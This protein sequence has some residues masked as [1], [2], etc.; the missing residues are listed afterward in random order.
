MVALPGEFACQ[1]KLAVVVLPREAGGLSPWLVATATRMASSIR[2]P[3][4]G[5]TF[6]D[7]MR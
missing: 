4:I 2:T 3:M 7:F 6:G 1:V 5:L